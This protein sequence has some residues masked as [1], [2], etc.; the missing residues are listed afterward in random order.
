MVSG[1]KTHA[2]RRIHEMDAVI[3]LLQEVGVPAH[4]SA[5]ARQRLIA[6]LAMESVE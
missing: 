6:L 2:R 4:T 3:E 5:A 1:S